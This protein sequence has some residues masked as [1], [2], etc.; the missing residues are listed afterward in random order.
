MVLDNQTA[1]IQV[2]DEVP[3]LTSQQSGTEVTSNVV[4]SIDYQD[5]G[6]ILTVTPRVTPGRLVIMEVEQ[7]VST[8][9][10]TESDI[11]SPTIRTRNISSTVAV[12]HEQAVILGGLIRDESSNTKGG[13]PGLYSLPGLGWVF[14]QQNKRARRNELVVVLTPRVI[15]NDNDIQKVTEDFRTR[16]Q[17]LRDKF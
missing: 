2:G 12:K 6:V 7:E 11:N 1:K 10:E 16:L 3:I 15:A 17:G 8:V 14:G 5:T 13:L 9:E 4:N